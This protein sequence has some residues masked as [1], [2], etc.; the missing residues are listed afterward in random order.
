MRTA[1]AAETRESLAD[2]RSDARTLIAEWRD[3]GRFT[4]RPD[5]WLRGYDRAFSK[6]LADHGFIGLTWPRE[7]GG[8]ERSNLARLV[9]TEELLRAG[10][11]VA[12]HW[13]ADRQIG[14]ALLRSGTRLL[15]EEFLPRIASGD[16]TFCL[17]MSETEAGSDLAAVRTRARRVDGGF[18]L[19]GSKIWTSQAHRSEYAY[20]LARTSDGEMKHEGLT[21]LIADMDAD[22]VTVRP[23]LDLQGEHHFNEVIFDGVFVSDHRIIGEVG[24][25]WR[26]VTEQLAFERG[27]PERVLSTYPLLEALLER[28]G[29]RGDRADLV[30]IGELAAR[31]LALRQMVWDVAL[32]MDRG[33][34]PVREAAILKQLGTAFEQDVAEQARHIL[35]VVPSSPGPDPT[36]LL[37]D[38]LMASPGFTIR[39]GTSE[40]LL[41]IIARSELSP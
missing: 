16:A 28:A 41:G 32:A 20:V 18:V 2:L 38:A 14:P 24:G 29:D 25:G 1:P 15:Q 22:G 5:A 39:G 13:I 27:G 6:A 35:G 33:E 40:V 9:V 37:G 34:A 7:L 12:A 19:D 8:S 26:Q 23:I 4:P 3:A 21:E 10:A 17:C 30:V 11:P 31:A 36:N